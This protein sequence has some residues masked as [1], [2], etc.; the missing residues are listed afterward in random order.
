M[1]SKIVDKVKNIPKDMINK[2][3]L[4]KYGKML[5]LKLDIKNKSIDTNILLNGEDKAILVHIDKYEMIQKADKYFIILYG[6][7]TSREWINLLAKDHIEGKEF[8]VPSVYASKLK[9]FI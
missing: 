3:I 2:H 5:D 6:I 1:F 9:L 7:H 8:I 4:N